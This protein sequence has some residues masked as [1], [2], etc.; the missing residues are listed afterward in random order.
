LT[1]THTFTGV[2]SPI[3]LTS[4]TGS[5]DLASVNGGPTVMTVRTQFDGEDAIDS[6]Q[7]SFKQSSPGPGPTSPVPGPLPILGASV[8]P[9]QIGSRPDGP[10]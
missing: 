8:A 1:A 4:T 5:S 10:R 9:R 2:N 7:H 6:I 3:A